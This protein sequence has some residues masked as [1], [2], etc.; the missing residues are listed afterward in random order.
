MIVIPDRKAVIITPPKCGS[1]TLHELLYPYGYRVDGPQFGKSDDIG[2]HTT[3]LT[4]G[5]YKYRVYCLIRDPRD[6]FASLYNHYIREQEYWTPEQFIEGYRNIYGF[7]SQTVREIVGEH[8][9][10]GVIRIEHV[11]QDIYEQFGLNVRTVV[12]NENR[13]S[14]CYI[15]IKAPYEFIE[16]DLPD[17]KN[18]G[19]DPYSIRVRVEAE[20]GEHVL[21]NETGSVGPKDP[22]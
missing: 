2:K 18:S 5:T 15:D 6:R 10:T 3:V 1:T 11:A 14:P 20:S 8:K 13:K 9:L 17:V 19:I 21:P 22:F 4:Y 7:Y 16:R 12:L